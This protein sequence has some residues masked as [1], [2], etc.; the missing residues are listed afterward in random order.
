V[1]SVQSFSARRPFAPGR[2]LFLYPIRTPTATHFTGSAR[3]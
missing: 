3:Q 2:R 1:N